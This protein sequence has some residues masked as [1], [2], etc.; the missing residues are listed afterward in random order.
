MTIDGDRGEGLLLGQDV[1]DGVAH[2]GGFRGAEIGLLPDR[3]KTR[4]DQ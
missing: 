2:V 1:V 4:G 3:R